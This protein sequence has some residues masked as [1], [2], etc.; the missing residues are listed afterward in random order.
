[1]TG[2]RSGIRSADTFRTLLVAA[3]GCV[4]GLIGAVAA[5]RLGV[6]LDSIWA[7]VPG[8]IGFRGIGMAAAYL[9][10]V[11]GLVMAVRRISEASLRRWMPWAAIALLVTV[12]ALVIPLIDT[13]LPEDNDP[14]FL[15]ELAVG[16]LDGGN[17]L[18]AHRPMGFSAMLATLY[19]AF[20]IHVWLAEVLNLT[21]AVVTGWML[22]RLVLNGWG[23][24]PAA[25]AVSLYAVMPS[26]ILLVT[27]VYT[28]IVYSALLLTA[29]LVAGLAVRSQRVAVGLASGAALAV[30]QYVR[31]LSEAF[32]ATFVLVPFLFSAGVARAAALA[33]ASVLGFVV[34]LAPVAAHNLITHGDVSLATSSYGGW[35]VFVG[36]NQEHTG[37]FNRED[38]AVLRD[39][40]GSVWERSEILGREGVERIGRD[41]RGFLELAV[42]KFRVMWG[43][44]AY[45]VGAALSGSATPEPIRQALELIS[46]TMYAAVAVA[47]A[48]G[49]WRVRRGAPPEALLVAGVILTI[50][51][52]HA[53][54]EVQPRYHA[55]A[56]PLLCAMAAL[57]PAGT[58]ATRLHPRRPEPTG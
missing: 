2:E 24:R 39:L 3:T 43:D 33:A 45:A 40:E 29:M 10:C 46:Q 19:A 50:V 14:L 57:A 8:E 7:E 56:V 22:H 31:P 42:R 12:R 34:V 13:P 30:S 41:P 4:V 58:A 44:D 5:I 53:V 32:L 23:T 16:V 54:V 48:V 6:R 49:L 25:L 38:Q 28:E 26:Q 35:S 47:A 36:T 20:G 37:M 18:V 9:G 52:A 17:W 51:A 21:F 15:H 11:A 1:M 27:T 55:Y